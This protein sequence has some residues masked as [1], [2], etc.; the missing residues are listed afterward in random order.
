MIGPVLDTKKSRAWGVFTALCDDQLANHDVAPYQSI[1]WA[2]RFSHLESNEQIEVLHFMAL[3]KRG[4]STASS[5]EIVCDGSSQELECPT[6]K[7][8]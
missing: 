1:H 5:H 7:S 4:K 3:Q 2:T 8:K 6:L